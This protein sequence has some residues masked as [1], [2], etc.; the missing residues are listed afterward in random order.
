MSRFG[1]I[2][3]LMLSGCQ[4]TPPA[5]QGWQALGTGYFQ[6]Y[7]HWPGRSQQL[8]QQVIWSDGTSQHQFTVS[9]LLQQDGILL[10]ALSPLGQELWRL[11][12]QQGNVLTVS[13]VAP[14]DQPTFARRLLAEMQLAL[15]DVNDITAHLQQLSLQQHE[16]QRFIMNTDGSKVLQITNAA[17]VDAGQ[18]INLQASTYSLQITTLQQDFLP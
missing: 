7:D 13:G 1:L 15:L 14:F 16:Q 17:N 9:A 11:Q 4:M 3:L 2:L 6:L 5:S 8:L 18:Q 10:V 12:Y